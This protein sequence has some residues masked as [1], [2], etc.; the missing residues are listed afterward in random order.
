MLKLV[1]CRDLDAGKGVVPDPYCTITFPGGIEKKSE[2]ISS[3][4]NPVFN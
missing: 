4:I 3:T 2:T 1:H